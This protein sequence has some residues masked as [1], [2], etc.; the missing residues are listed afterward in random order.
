MESRTLIAE[1]RTGIGGGR[2]KALRRMGKLPAVLYGPGIQPQILQLDAH[3]SSKALMQSTGATLFDLQVGDETHK[4]LVREMQRDYIR[5]ELLHVDFLKVAMDVA[6]RAEVPIELVG[7]APAVKEFGGVLVPGISEIEV[8][9]L[10]ADLPD[11]I[12]VDLEALR[13]IEDSITVADL[14]VG[15]NVRVLTDPNETVAHVIYQAA[16]VEEVEEEVVEGAEAVAAEPEL[17][18]RGK[19]EEEEGEGAE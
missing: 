12:M 9:A 4:V 17:V 18:E 6:I 3:D 5:N 19:R 13:N 16:E 1:T 7:T 8:E 10:P 15:K 2:V 14:F 11:R